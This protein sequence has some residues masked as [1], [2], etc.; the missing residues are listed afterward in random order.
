MT[1]FS[2]PRFTAIHPAKRQKLSKLY[3]TKKLDM[4]GSFKKTDV[5]AK[6]L[7]YDY[8]M[9]GKEQKAR[10]AHAANI[11][12]VCQ[13]CGRGGGVL[14]RVIHL[15]VIAKEGEYKM[16]YWEYLWNIFLIYM[17][18]P[19]SKNI[20]EPCIEKF[21]HHIWA[22]RLIRMIEWIIS[23]TLLLKSQR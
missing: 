19:K 3:H 17:H 13:Y 14:W 18:R 22:I 12:I 4:N 10:G 9:T 6:L 1:H 16:Y 11:S 7:C 20:I 8:Q 21:K 2:C 15:G 23:V 5:F